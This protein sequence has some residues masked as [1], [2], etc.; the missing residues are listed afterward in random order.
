MT[1]TRQIAFIDRSIAD[2]ETLL[3]GLNE[4]IQVVILD[5]S[6]DGL[7]QIAES[8]R[9]TNSVS[10]IHIFSHGSSGEIMLGDAVLNS[11]NLEQYNAALA[12][13]GNALT[14]TG[15]ILL[16]GCNVAQGEAGLQFIE[17]WGRSPGR[18]S[19]PQQI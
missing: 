5:P 4:D 14:A 11:G 13:I 1:A 3:A 2:W 18:M 10:A 7:L 12:T 15:D 9:G 17:S 16:Y 8:L 6:T 19:R